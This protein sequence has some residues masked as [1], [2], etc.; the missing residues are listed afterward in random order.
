MEKTGLSNWI[1]PYRNNRIL[2]SFSDPKTPTQVQA[3]LGIGKFN[4]K[5]FLKRSLIKCLNPESYKGRLY[6]LTNKSRKLLQVSKWKNPAGKDWNLAGWILSSPKQ[7]YVVLKTLGMDSVRRTSEEI[8]KR[9]SGL[10]P[11]LSRISTKSILKELVNRDLLDTE[12]GSDQKR[13]YWINKEGKLLLNDLAHLLEGRF[14][15][16]AF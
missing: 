6:V 13:Y 4:L 5:P 3:D 14:R 9:T 1:S 2:M 11:C 7:R 15:E 12:I 10:N 16:A 8:R